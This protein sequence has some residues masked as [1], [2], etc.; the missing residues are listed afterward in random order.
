MVPSIEQKVAIDEY[1]T[2]SNKD[3]ADKQQMAGPEE[4]QDQKTDKVQTTVVSK[5]FILSVLSLAIGKPFFLD[6]N[7]GQK[8]DVKV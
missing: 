1:F 6:P 2:H 7:V 3:V 5:D 8:I 4:N